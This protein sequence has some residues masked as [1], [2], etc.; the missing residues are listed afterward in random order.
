MEWMQPWMQQG[1][2]RVTTLLPHFLAADCALGGNKEE[3]CTG[4]VVPINSSRQWRHLSWPPS[5]I[6]DISSSLNVKRRV[7]HQV[8]GDP[9]FGRRL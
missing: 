3:G 2:Q 4:W 6:C 1:R 7:L 5:V 8:E 9:N